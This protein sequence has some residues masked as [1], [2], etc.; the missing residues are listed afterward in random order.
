M[1]KPKIFDVIAEEISKPARSKYPTR[2]VISNFPDDIWASDLAQMTTFTSQ[3]DGYSYMLNVIDLFTRYA[4]SVPLKT[5]TAKEVLEGM[6]IIVKSNG[7]KTPRFLWVDEGKEYHNNELKKWCKENDVTMYS[8]HGTHKS[9]V[10]ERFNKTIKTYMWRRFIADNTRN[11]VEMLPSLITFYNNKVHRGINMTPKKAHSLNN[12]QISDLWEF[13]FGDVPMSNP[14]PPK[15]KIGDYVRISRKKDIF[16]K[17][18]EPS[19]TMEIFKIRKIL[20]TVPWTYH[21]EDLKGEP[22]IGSF[23]EP[24]MM[25]TQQTPESEFLVEKVLAR[26]KVKGQEQVLVKWLGYSDKFN[27]WIDA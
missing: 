6:K 2:K 9:V 27:R 26:R 5:K 1:S 14:K 23:Y 3:N 13:Q 7:G 24:D 25:R 4:W 15:F 17:G 22:I 18:F 19:W 12:D 21:L 16:E 10:V 11:W 20:K 8:T